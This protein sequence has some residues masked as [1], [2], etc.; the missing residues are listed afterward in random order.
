MD[1]E[2]ELRFRLIAQPRLAAVAGFA[3]CVLALGC[4]NNL[5]G[6]P[7]RVA[8]GAATGTGATGGASQSG[9]GGN[10]TGAGT[11]TGGS[12]GS[13][14]GATDSVDCSAPRAASV[15]ARLLSSRQYNHSVLDLLNVGGNPAQN[16]GDKV[17]EQ[18]DDTRVEQRANVAADV[19]RQAV[20]NLSSWSPCM[21][22]VTGSASACEQQIIDKVGQLA[23]RRPL[24]VED[25]AQMKALFDAGIQEK[26]FATGVEWYLTGLLQ[27]PDFMYEIALP[28]PGET[29]GEVRLLRPHEYASRL[30]HFL[31]DSPPDEALLSAATANE[32]AEPVTRQTHVDRMLGDPRLMRGL[33]AFYSRWLDLSAFHEVARDAAGFDIAVVD[34]LSQSLLMSATELY[35]GASPNISQLFSGETYYLNDALRTFYGLSG[36]GSSFA[37]SAMTGE[38]RYGVLTHPAMMAMLARPD[39]SFPIGRGLFIVRTLLCQPVPLPNGLVIP[40]LPPIQDGLST[41]DRLEA[42]T[43]NAVCAGCHSL[44][45]P[46]G[47][48]LENF[49]EVGRFRTVDHGISVD[50]SGTLAIDSDLDGDFANGGEFLAKFATSKDVR[51]CFVE[52]Y[53]TFA[54]S[55]QEPAP[56]DACSIQTLGQSFAPTGD[57][58][59]L[60]V[61]IVQSDAFRMRLAEG[62]AR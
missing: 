41:R 62:I 26:D 13:S 45:D 7:N 46:A 9:N 21:P 3:V 16:L 42:H 2:S 6:A 56:E 49:D 1:H 43:S 59:Q 19:A 53:L 55:R 29:P 12:A 4:E 33:E 47:F 48:A 60:A 34:A 44:F 22:P 35:R 50:T 24:T 38:G 39:E 40:E 25:G 17:Y 18:L 10:G 54:L 61:S 23:F 58:K 14:G 31:W 36:A 20:M 30:A 27:S 52:Q 32:L 51:T 15:R 57:L 11:G 8:Q 37:P 5:A 28:D